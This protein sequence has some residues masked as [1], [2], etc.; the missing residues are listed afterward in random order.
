MVCGEYDLVPVC[1]LFA[2]VEDDAGEEEGGGGE[3]EGGQELRGWKGD[4]FFWAVK[5]GCF[6]E[7]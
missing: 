5:T 6:D 4:V 2:A 1:V 3:G 7:L